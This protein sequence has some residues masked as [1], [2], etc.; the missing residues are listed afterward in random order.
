MADIPLNTKLTEG[1]VMKILDEHSIPYEFK[2]E[3]ISAGGGVYG[4]KRNFRNTT[5]K[6]IRDYLGY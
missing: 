6:T 4:R 3:G 5:L 1:Q 2:G